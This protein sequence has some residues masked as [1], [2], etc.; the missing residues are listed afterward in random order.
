MIKKNKK[1][2]KK[3]TS[4]TELAETYQSVILTVTKK[5]TF[6][7]YYFIRP[8]GF[9][10]VSIRYSKQTILDL[11]LK[12]NTLSVYERFF[13]LACHAK[14]VLSIVFRF[15]WLLTSMHGGEKECL[16]YHNIYQFFKKFRRSPCSRLWPSHIRT[17]ELPMW[18]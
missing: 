12:I 2:K 8:F 3:Y 10:L 15:D 7:Y 1:N 11:T 5:K 9:P 17:K 14:N 13:T 6:S 16:Y 4:H 18:R